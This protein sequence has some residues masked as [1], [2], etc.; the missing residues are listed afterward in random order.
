MKAL[1][2][3]RMEQLNGGHSS[4]AQ[5]VAAVV[6]T[7]ILF[8]AIPGGFLFGAARIAVGYWRGSALYD[9]CFK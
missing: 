5:E 8:S 9:A 1:E 7:T 3:E 4:C 2:L 6:G